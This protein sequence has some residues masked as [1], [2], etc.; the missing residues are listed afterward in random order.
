MVNCKGSRLR[1]DWNG[2]EGLM[3]TDC[4]PCPRAPGLKR[5]ESERASNLNG[6]RFVTAVIINYHS[7]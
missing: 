2:N 4:I 5:I 7:F 6:H 1:S 3:N